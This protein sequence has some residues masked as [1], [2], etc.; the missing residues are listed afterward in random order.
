MLNAPGTST[1]QTSVA[2]STTKAAGHAAIRDAS[3]ISHSAYITRVLASA[4][5]QVAHYMWLQ[6]ADTSSQSWDGTQLDTHRGSS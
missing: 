3:S 2:R 6:I 4:T 5:K 1:R